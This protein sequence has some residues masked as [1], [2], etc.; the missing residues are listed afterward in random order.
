MFDQQVITAAMDHARAKFPCEACGLVVDSEYLPRENTADDPLNDFR[1]A[2]QAFVAASR[3]GEVQAVIHSHPK[4]PD[5][6]SHVDQV[7][8]L[9]MGLAW[10]IV[11]FIGQVPQSPFFWGGDT[12]IAPLVGRPFRPVAADCYTLF[13]DWLRV[14]RDVVLPD[15]ERSDEWWDGDEDNRFMEGVEAIG[16]RA[17]DD[18]PKLG[19][20]VLMQVCSSKVNHC[21]I[22]VGNG[23][24]LHHLQNRLSR[25]EP[26]IR[27]RK[28]VRTII[29][30]VQS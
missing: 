6:P 23:L 4:G 13:R 24:L 26:Y 7:E 17:V 11:P 21:G 8:Q 28:H 15:L 10:G 22:Y 14:H 3:K 16:F 19:D 12:P 1:I 27:W 2:P 29:R 9:R 5:W 18:D 30:R 25:E 20:G